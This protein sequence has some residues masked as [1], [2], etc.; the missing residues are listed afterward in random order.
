MYGWLQKKYYENKYKTSKSVYII[1][2][3]YIE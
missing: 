2:T 1:N 3:K